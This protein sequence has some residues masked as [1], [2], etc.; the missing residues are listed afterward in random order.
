M[1]FPKNAFL[2]W[3]SGDLGFSGGDLVNLGHRWRSKRKQKEEKEISKE[4]KKEKWWKK[5]IFGFIFSLRSFSMM[6][7]NYNCIRQALASKK[8]GRNYFI[9]SFLHDEKRNKRI[10]K[11]LKALRWSFVAL[12]KAVRTTTITAIIAQE[13]AAP[14]FSLPSCFFFFEEI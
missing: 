4:K 8:S 7:K 2:G 9:L 14:N 13:S 6:R 1:K 3:P 5:L 10:K 12:I 11:N